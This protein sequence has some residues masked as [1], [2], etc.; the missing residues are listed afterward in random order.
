M[1][2]A[3]YKTNYL[4]GLMIPEFTTHDSWAEAQHE[5]QPRAFILIHNQEVENS[6]ME[7]TLG[8]DQVHYQHGTK[9]SRLQ[10]DM[11]LEEL[12]VLHLF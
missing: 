12:G 11:V 10:A 1:I 8:M 3:K 7:N 6:G 5:N 9:H 4:I 2:K